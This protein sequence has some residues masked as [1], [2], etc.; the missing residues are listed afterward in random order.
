MTFTYHS[1]LVDSQKY[2][3]GILHAAQ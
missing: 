2:K 3:Q 1:R